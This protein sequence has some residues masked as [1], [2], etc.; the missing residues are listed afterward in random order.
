M[1]KQYNEVGCYAY[2]DAQSVRGDVIGLLTIHKR[3]PAWD[4]RHHYIRHFLNSHEDMGHG[5]TVIWSTN[6][7]HQKAD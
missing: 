2:A 3:E 6:S 4:K 7:D 1:K 5:V